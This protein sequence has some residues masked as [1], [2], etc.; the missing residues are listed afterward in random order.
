MY[1]FVFCILS[2]IFPLFSLLSAFSGGLGRRRRGSPAITT[3]HR[4]ASRRSAGL[5]RDRTSRK[6]TAA[7]MALRAACI[8]NNILITCFY[9]N[10]QPV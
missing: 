9:H 2:C 7:A 8:K 6:S 10:S 1:F 4:E 5:G 3:G